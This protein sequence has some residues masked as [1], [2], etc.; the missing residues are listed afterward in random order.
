VEP[1]PPP[2]PNQPEPLLLVFEVVVGPEKSPL[3]VD[4]GMG[5]APPVADEG[6]V[7]AMLVGTR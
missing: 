2:D 3:E 5:V 1:P 6:K 4:V 7:R